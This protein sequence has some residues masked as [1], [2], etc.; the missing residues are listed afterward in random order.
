MK[1][2]F[3]CVRW[4]LARGATADFWFFAQS[5]MNDHTCALMSDGRVF[6]WG[7][8]FDGQVITLLICSR[9]GFVV[10]ALCDCDVH[11]S[12]S[13]TLQAGIDTTMTP[14]YT[15]R[16]VF[17]QSLAV[18]AGTVSLSSAHEMC[19]FTTS[20]FSLLQLRFTTAGTLPR[21]Q[22]VNTIS[23]TNAL[24]FYAACR[25]SGQRSSRFE[26]RVT[27]VPSTRLGEC[28]VGERIRMG[29]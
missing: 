12:L 21:L 4:I 5:S 24:R 6:C 28:S 2:C 17:T 15:P 8:N 20:H 25:L 14:Q 29:R 18:S 16:E 7:Y 9:A 22:L 27:L 11:T 19:I 23:V 26:C 3:V 1:R 10:A 13:T